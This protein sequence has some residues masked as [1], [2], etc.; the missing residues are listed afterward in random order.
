[1]TDD[2]RIAVVEKPGYGWSEG[3]SSSRDIDTTLGE[4]RKALNLAGE[5]GPYV[6][7]PH[8]MSG[9][10]AIYW[11]QKY[12]DEVK[13]VIGLDP[14]IPD[15]YLDPSFKLP[16]RSELYLT[17]LMSRIGLTRFM[18][19]AGLEKNLP[20][21]KSEEL[22][23][24]DKEKL[25]AIFYRS[26]L[27]KTMLNELNYIQE[28]VRKVKSKGIPFDTPMY[29]FIAENNVDIIPTWEEE[30]SQYVSKTDYGKFKLLESGHYVHHE[31]SYDIANEMKD[32]LQK[33]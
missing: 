22:S 21:L 12:P 33:I 24:E 4:T 10:E 8:S 20:L 19:R 9:L 5:D 28:N 15:V 17:Y 14:A 26:S 13:A 31:K 16:R 23:E 25:K 7:V 27:T 18:G 6:L 1:M 29:F 11:A 2:Y 32:F 3:S 30:L